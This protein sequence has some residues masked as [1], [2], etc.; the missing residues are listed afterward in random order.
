M[1]AFLFALVLL[2]SIQIPVYA[3]DAPEPQATIDAEDT[4]LSD[5]KIEQR[6]SSIFEKI[7]GTEEVEVDV[8]AGVVSLSGDVANETAAR[9]ALD[10]AGRTD[11]VVTVED[12]INRTLDVRGNVAP[13]LQGFQDDLRNIYR[14]LPL[15]VLSLIVFIAFGLFG[16]WL[17]RRK[18]LWQRV[19]PNPFLAEIV[20]QIVRLAFWA[21][22]AIIALNLVGASSLI[23][24][25]LGGAGVVG[26]AIGFAVRD[27]LEN[28]ISS[29]MLSL[30][31]PFRAQDHV[32]IND[33]EGIVVRLTSRAT[34]LMTLEGN[35]L[36]IPNSTVFKGTIL[37]Y[38]TNP[39]RRFEFDVGV[40]GADDP[41][42]AMQ[43]GLEAMKH[44]DFVL[45]DPLPG[46]IIE[47]IGDSNIVIRFTGWVDQTVT[48]FG[49]ARSY[50]I[51][52]VI[53]TLDENGF[54][55]P[56]PIYRLRFDGDIKGAADKLS[57]SPNGKGA[58][59]ASLSEKTPKPSAVNAK[60]PPLDVSKDTHL[61]EKVAEER[62]QTGED[63]L[64]DENKPK[65]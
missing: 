56:E 38:T 61:E 65:E 45:A 53:N 39:E 51:R 9:D 48:D 40:D 26:I 36:R 19:S 7:S 50:A 29:I 33:L 15:I 59:T 64:L 10:I 6:L 16:G 31:Q 57:S 43:I 18:S 4:A 62:E 49:K 46:A 24:T 12:N 32:V 34:I 54:T 27:S 47:T 5:Q 11:G 30:R 63:D 17:A 21:I 14:A 23:A 2:F 58:K 13:V 37:N 55:M 28:Y 20:A 35:H 44:H 52:S 42:S 41:V 25:I 60:T 1:R 22:G 8:S 3:Q